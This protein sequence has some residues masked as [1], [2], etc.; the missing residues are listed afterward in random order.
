MEGIAQL[1]AEDLHKKRGEEL[2]S[3][4]QSTMTD[5]WCILL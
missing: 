1:V 4:L 5:K 3:F 2:W